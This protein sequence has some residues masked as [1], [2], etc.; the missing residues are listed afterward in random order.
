MP[1]R[2]FAAAAVAGAL[3]AVAFVARGGG[4][5]TV[6]TRKV[7]LSGVLEDMNG[8]KV[9]LA[10]FAG[11][12]VVINLWATW[13][14]PCKLETPQLVS[15]SEKF[16]SRGLTILGISVDDLPDAIRAFA[17]EFKVSYP[18]L[19]GVGHEDFIRHLG[20]QEVLPF[21]I[22]VDKT[23]TVVGEITGIE[24][25]ADWERRIESLLK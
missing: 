20:Y 13:C 8:G 7:E 9:D 19:V 15:L 4:G 25:T 3:M 17:S 1:G 5:S 18:M 22:L 16:K 14:G 11:K 12:P 23:G 21:S 6:P 24:T 10:S 2:I